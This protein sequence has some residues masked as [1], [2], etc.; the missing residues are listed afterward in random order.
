MKPK[1]CRNSV[2][3][4]PNNDCP[5]SRT[6]SRA[7]RQTPEPPRFVRKGYFLR[8]ADHRRI[9]RW[10]CRNCGRSFSSSTFH[11]CF[12]QKKRSVNSMVLRLLASGVTY[13]RTAILLGL[14]F[15]SVERKARYW[16]RVAQLHHRASLKDL[17]SSN[18]KLTEVQFD[19]LETF[20]RSK[21]LPLSVPLMVDAKSRRILGFRVC[22]MPAN[23]PLAKVSR[24]KYGPRKDGR[25]RAALRLFREL[26]PVIDSK[27][28]ITTDQKSTYP[29]WIRTH[30]PE[31][32]HATVKGR[33]G[34]IVGQGELKKVGY[35]PL[36][37]LNHTC[38][39]LRANV[40]RL[41][42]KTWSTTKRGD[43]LARHLRLYM[44]YHNT[45]L[46]K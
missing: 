46:I 9:P 29:Q 3:I 40:S 21:C 41:I 1:F 45:Q 7:S 30:L 44:Y 35:D 16:D 13:R 10:E 18:R 20:E 14:N 27:A 42:R 5:S 22:S 39:M 33:R 43:R 6:L 37:S 12:R 23:G 31:V 15:K 34:A 4:C 25:K 36:F 32:N 8:K 11:P 17:M 19:E 24:E 38:A 28:V 26:A 2:L